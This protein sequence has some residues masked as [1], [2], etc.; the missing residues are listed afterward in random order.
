MVSL[1]VPSRRLAA[2]ALVVLVAAVVGLRHVHGHA[3]AAPLVVAPVRPRAAAARPAVQPTVVVDVEGAVRRPGL[4]RLPKASRVA[5][6]VARAGGMTAKAARSGVNL[7]APVSDGQQV[8]VPGAG[9]AGAVGPASGSGSPPAPVS[10]SSATPEQ[11]DALPGIGPAT[12]Q[13][14]VDYRAQHGAFRS[15]DELDAIPGIGPARIAELQ[16]LVTP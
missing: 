11:L 13:K 16:G 3:R 5:D 2:A 15:V 7:A 10:L 6:A 4:V 14:I 12:A 9:V 8:L 1:P